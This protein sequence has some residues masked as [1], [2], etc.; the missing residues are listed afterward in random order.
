[1]SSTGMPKAYDPS[2]V[3]ERC[4]QRWMEDDCFRARVD[5]QRKPF[6][7]VI[8]PPNVTG[9]LHMGHALNNTLQ[10]ILVRWRRMQGY[11][12]LWVPGTDHAGIATQHVVEN[13]LAEEGLSK[14]QLGREAFLKRIWSWKEH[15]EQLI[16]RQLKRLG[17]SCDWSRLRF[18]LDERCSRAVREVFVK[19]YERG[20]IYRGDYIINWCPECGTALSDLEVEHEEVNGFLWYVRYPLVDGDGEV[21]VATTRPETILGDTAVAVHPADARYATLVGRKVRLPIIGREIPV[22]ADEAV[23][24][25]FGTG[26]VKVTPA[27]DPTDFEIALR[28]RLPRVVAMDTSARMTEAAG[29][30][31][32]MDRQECRSK[33]L[34]DLDQQGYLVRREPHHHAVGH[35]YRCHSVVEPMVSKQWFVKIK[36][37]ARAAIEAVENGEIRFVPE[38][39]ARIYLNWM[40]NLRDWCISRQLWWGHRIPVWYCQECGETIAARQD[41]ESCRCGSLSLKQDPDV[42]DTWFSSA[43]WPFSTL[44]W[45][46]S[47]PELGHFYPNSVLVTAYDIIFFWV[48]R[49]IMMGL[50]F[51]GSR[52]F[53][54]VLIHGLVRDPLGRKMSK[55]LGIGI[56][57]LEVVEKYGADALRYALVTGTTPGNDT[58]FHWERVEA[59]RNFV[60]KVWNAARFCLM[61]LENLESTRP[62]EL[63]LTDRW[64]L[65]RLQRVIRDTTEQM[66][67]Y[68][69]GEAARILYDF[70]WDEFCD[71]YLELVKP[72]LYGRADADSAAA[73]RWTLATVLRTLLKLLH[74]Y[75][76]FVT[77]E[78]WGR[79]P[80]CQGHLTLSPWPTPSD[81]LLDEEAEAAMNLV[82]EV[83]RAF[84][85]LR[86]EL[87]VPRQAMVRGMVRA[88]DADRA[89]VIEGM[90]AYVTA[91]TGIDPLEVG[92]SS[93]ERSTRAAAAVLAGAEV[94]LPVPELVDLDREIQRAE[95]A[96]ARAREDLQRSQNKLANQD[97]VRKASPEVVA[98]ERQKAEELQEKVSGL[99]RRLRLLRSVR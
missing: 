80:G 11:S 18:T 15:H 76:P 93:P 26:A 5:P 89:R 82:M 20:L 53:D 79:M 44:G 32:G 97:F 17:A 54:V 91:L 71:W 81:E 87:G 33:I 63:H 67:K 77:E 14:E 13:R 59:S 48:A 61:Q 70:T 16:V 43:L 96:L 1:M 28:H 45:P 58:R 88:D 65:S 35:C 7:I 57:P 25:D 2:Q 52:P 12:V 75:I 64:V 68:Q 60:N 84:R 85:H 92:M 3:E 74:P 10:D 4:Y 38:R 9:E 47:T 8:P 46:D 78:I 86:S 41:P 42:L 6:C 55:S 94:Y 49:M 50:E 29:P 66:E 23:D 72:R 21:V 73:A 39:F 99:E 24:P 69:L 62:S 37:L 98:R 40:E 27:H 83:V 30:Y 95:K 56:D 22:V 90:K 36:P 19:L 34:E 51:M 31:Q